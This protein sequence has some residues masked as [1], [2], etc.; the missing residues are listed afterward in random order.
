[1][2]ERGDTGLCD[3]VLN[4]S[5]EGRGGCR[6]GMARVVVAQWFNNRLLIEVA[7]GPVD[8]PQRASDALLCSGVLL[9]G[10]GG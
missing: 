10:R 9:H 4:Q 5:E 7:W 2:F 3:A 8:C 1:M 6:N